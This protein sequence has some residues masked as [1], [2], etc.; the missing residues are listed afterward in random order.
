MYQRLQRTGGKSGEF[1]RS[2]NVP[3]EAWSK[4]FTLLLTTKTHKN[5]HVQFIL[6]D[7][8]SPKLQIHKLISN[9]VI[10][11][12]KNELARWLKW[13]QK[14][15]HEGE[16]ASH[17]LAMLQWHW[18]KESW[19]WSSIK[20]YRYFAKRLMFGR[21]KIFR[22]RVVPTHTVH[23]TVPRHAARSRQRLW[24]FLKCQRILPL[25]QEEESRCFIVSSAVMYQT[26]NQSKY[27]KSKKA[28]NM[29]RKSKA[30][31]KGDKNNKWLEA[32]T[33]NCLK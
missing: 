16:S 13:S 15:K 33:G 31:C 5:A 6:W 20:K 3:W 32:V 30:T 2:T 26:E 12:N 1:S 19:L 23:E 9:E 22:F 28:H 17:Y 21:K 7:P 11:A 29:C 27:Q 18:Q 10:G 25:Q 4:T 8:K 14:I 24:C